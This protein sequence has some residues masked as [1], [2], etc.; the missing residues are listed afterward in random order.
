MLLLTNVRFR[1]VGVYASL[2]DTG[3]M[4]LQH[5]QNPLYCFGRVFE[6]EVKFGKF[7]VFFEKKCG[8]FSWR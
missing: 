4:L 6:L 8:E 3:A 2:F 5:S 7:L 1:K